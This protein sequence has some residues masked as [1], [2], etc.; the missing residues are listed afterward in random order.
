M[1]CWV[2]NKKKEVDK[3]NKNELQRTDRD[4]LKELLKIIKINEV[5]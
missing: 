4:N 3:I 2:C 1:Y 5:N